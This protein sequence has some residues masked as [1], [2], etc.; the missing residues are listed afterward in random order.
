MLLTVLTVRS[1]NMLIILLPA[2]F[3]PKRNLN[4]LTR[5]GTS[6]HDEAGSRAQF[7]LGVGKAQEP[8]GVPDI[9]LGSGCRDAT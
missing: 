2:A 5:E 4:F 7:F 3:A 9:L 1:A 8:V 6:A